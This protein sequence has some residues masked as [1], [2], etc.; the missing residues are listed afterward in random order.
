MLIIRKKYVIIRG[1]DNGCP[2]EKLKVQSNDRFG[3]VWVGINRPRNICFICSHLREGIAIFLSSDRICCCCYCCF[4]FFRISEFSFI[5]AVLAEFT[6][7]LTRI[8][9]SAFLLHVTK[10]Y[11]FFFY[12]AL[13]ITKFN[14]LYNSALRFHE[15]LYAALDV[16]LC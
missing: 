3:I 15:R 16:D 4:F 7:H 9:V 10:R 8:E 14:V 12:L 11:T 5:H 1:G 6:Q 2:R 13:D